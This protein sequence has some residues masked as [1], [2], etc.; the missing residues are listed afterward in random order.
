MRTKKY[1]PWNM[2]MAQGIRRRAGAMIVMI[3]LVISVLALVSFLALL[4]SGYATLN[5]LS[6]KQ[7]LQAQGGRYLYYVLKQ[8]SGFVLARARAGTNNQPV[9]TPRVVASFGND[10]G[11]ASTDTIISLQLSPDSRYLAI[12]GTRSDGEL[13]WLFDTRRL[14]LHLDPANASGTFLHWLPGP[15]DTF[16]YRPMFPRGPDAPLNGGIWNPGLWEIDANTGGIMN[17]D[18]HTPSAFLV[19][20]VPSPDGTQIIYS[21]SSSLGMGSEV[22]TMDIHGHHQTRLLQLSGSTRNIAGLFAWSPDGRTIAY[23]RLAD[24]PTPFL[25]A[26][27]WLMNRQGSTQHFLAQADG[28]HGFPL[29]WSPDGRKIA[30]VARTNPTESAADQN[31]Q[32]LKSAIE[33]VD[34]NSRQVLMVANPAQTGLQ[35]NTAP[36]WDAE[37]SRITFT[38]SQPLNPVL[39]GT[40][41]YWS[42]NVR[43]PGAAPSVT[44]LAQAVV[45]VIAFV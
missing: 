18:I 2:K 37:S 10:F 11:Q 29:A 17:I 25:P 6:Y 20:A 28:G 36:A 34:V 5:T 38:A 9:E 7:G 23:E 35:I 33:V 19:D 44:S 14:M 26:G 31:M 21:T 15:D 16:L 41:T 3:T 32:A 30:F 45:H 22:W 24:S 4:H 43:P 27:I 39:G 42:A 13:L 8:S 1:T 40:I 12:D